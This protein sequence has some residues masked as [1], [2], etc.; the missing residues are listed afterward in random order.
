VK[1]LLL[2]AAVCVIPATTTTA[3]VY[4]ARVELSEGTVSMIRT[5]AG[6]IVIGGADTTPL[7][8]VSVE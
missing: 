2:I 5:T 8:G 7:R 1:K 3:Q 4:D 6:P